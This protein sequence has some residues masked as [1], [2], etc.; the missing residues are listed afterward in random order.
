MSTSDKTQPTMADLQAQLAAMQAENDA[1]KAKK[2]VPFTLKVG[3]KGGVCAYGLQRFPV[4]LYAN[5]WERLLGKADVIRA[6]IA[7]NADSLASK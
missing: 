1:L 5:Q 3:K 7:E 2:V 4:T 6:F